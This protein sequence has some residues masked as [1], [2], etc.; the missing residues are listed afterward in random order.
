MFLTAGPESMEVDTPLEKPNTD[1]LYL[2]L[3]LD[4]AVE[5]TVA[6]GNS[7]GTIRW[8]GTLPGRQETMAGLE[9]V[10]FVLTAFLCGLKFRWNI[11]YTTMGQCQPVLK[12]FWFTF[13]WRS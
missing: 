6:T 2:D 3:A 8:I 5:V 1:D 11:L 10:L 7:Y 12:R 9:L 4:S 13:F